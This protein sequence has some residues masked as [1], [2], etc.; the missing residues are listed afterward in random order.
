MLVLVEWMPW[1]AIAFVRLRLQGL[2]LRAMPIPGSTNSPCNGTRRRHS[3]FTRR[4]SITGTT[5]VTGIRADRVGRR[6]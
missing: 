6:E 5:A 4:A 3:D 2:A 1:T